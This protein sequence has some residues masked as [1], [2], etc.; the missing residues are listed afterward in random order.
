MKRILAAAWILGVLV[1]SLRAQAPWGVP[2]QRGVAAVTCAAPTNDKMGNPVP[3]TAAFTF[4]LVDIRGPVAVDYGPCDYVF[5]PTPITTPLWDA[6]QYHHPSWTAES[7]GNVFGITLDTRGDI[8]VAA[9]GLFGRYK[10][11]YHRY[12]NIGGGPASLAAAGTVYRISGTTGSVSVFSVIPG[13]QAM[14]LA[15][16]WSGTPALVSGP[17]LGNL[18]HDYDHNQFFVSSLE[19]GKIYRIDAAGTVLNSFDPLA[20]DTGAVGMPPRGDRIWAVEYE[21]NAV[22][23][24]VWNNGDASSPC[25]IR[26]I[27]LLPSG[28]FDATS[29]AAVVTIPPQAWVQ[30]GGSPVSDI[31]FTLNGTRM[32]AGVRTMIN[33]VTAYNH[34]S[35]THVIELIGSVWT[36]VKFLRTGCNQTDGESYGGVALGE[37]GGIQDSILWSSSADMAANNGPHGIFGVRMTDVPVNAQAVNSWKVPYIP[38]FTNGWDEDAKGS[39]GDVEILR[40]RDDCADVTVTAI[41]CPE[42]PGGAYTLDVSLTHHLA[43]TLV[44]YLEFK[45][46]PATSLPAGAVTVQPLPA[47]IQTLTPALAAG[48]PLTTTITLPGLPSSG[49][50]VCFN[51]K[52]LNATGAQCC[53][54]KI[55]VDLPA[56]DCAELL[57]TDIACVTD[58]ATGTNKYTLTFTVHN[59]TNL[60]TSPYAFSG[61]TFLP[62][63]GFDQS[64]IV[65]SPA[66]IPPGGTGTVS[67]CYYGTPGPLCFNLAL[68]DGTE[69]QCCAIEKICLDLPACDPIGNEDPKPD[70]CGLEGRVACCPVERTA[71]V[72]FTVCNNSNSPRTYHWNVTS[73]PTPACPVALAA[74]DFSP[75]S[76]MLG[77][78]PPGGCMTATVTIRCDTLTGDRRCAPFEFCARFD[79]RFPPLCCRG[80]VYRPEPGEAVVKSGQAD[81]TPLAIAPG[82]ETTMTVKLENPAREPRTVSLFFVNELGVLD[83][84]DQKGNRLLLTPV[85]VTVPAGGTLLVPVRVARRDNGDATGWTSVAVFTTGTEPVLEVPLRLSGGDATGALPTIT[86]ITIDA[87]AAPLVELRVITLPGR[88]YQVQENTD[89]GASW[90]DTSCIVA[91]GGESANGTFIGTGGEVICHVP[92]DASS[93]RM[94]YR[95][96]RRD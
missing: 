85:T 62:P 54:E 10:P 73:T 92:C 36:P 29:D 9:H 6:P 52:F 38:N 69:E 13:Q 46:C 64:S 78:I 76:G 80:I 77:P 2:M 50:K 72:N 83:F 5:P 8:Y 82:G 21:S 16:D 89:L 26:R 81:G 53:L 71:T 18:T 45:P 12:G 57:D 3:L 7:L 63:G 65:F 51:I 37:E 56:C 30:A 14:P 93:P 48:V 74:A 4:G 40:E 39:G 24:S 84:A 44:K 94:F 68:H 55:C 31:T 58:P 66:S 59:Q 88:I 28:D 15:T 96:V 17:G 11:Y 33:D 79:D 34:N 91:P 87:K 67:I 41:H 19:D 61:A 75:S 47:S 32:I 22:Y 25:V 70:T 23:Y 1:T 49:G 20:P 27:N 60:S 90:S 43:G 86:Q 35:G 95:V 42:K